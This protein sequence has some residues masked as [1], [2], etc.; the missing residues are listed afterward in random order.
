MSAPTLTERRV[1]APDAAATT[2]L[3]LALSTAARPGDLVCLWGELGAGKTHLAKAFGAGLG[4]TE[5]INSPS[6]ILMAEYAGRLPLF[7]IDLYRLGDAS[8][9]VAGGLIDDRQATGVTLVEWPDRMAAIL[10]VGRLDVFID[11]AGDDP[12]TITLRAGS[13]DLQR[14]LDAVP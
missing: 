13:A 7:H 8:D 2:A 12:R 9:V 4:V 6:F 5:T 11:G 14:Y 1:D 3:G 10:P